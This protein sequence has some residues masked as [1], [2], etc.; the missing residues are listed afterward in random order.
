MANFFERLFRRNRGKHSVVERLALINSQANGFFSF[1]S[2]VYQSDLVRSATRP[3]VKACGKLSVRHV[4]ETEEDFRASPTPAIRI[5]LEDP[6]AFMGMQ[7]MVEKVAW[8]VKLNGNAFIYIKRNKESD[9]A[10]L[11]VLEA[12]HVELLEATGD[13]ETFLRFRFGNGK[14]QVVPYSDIIHLRGEFNDNDFFGDSPSRVLIPLMECVNAQDQGIINAIK[15]SSVIKWLLRFTSSLRPEDIEKQT[16]R[17]A[18]QYLSLDSESGGV[19]GVDSK[20]E[21]TPIKQDGQF[22]PDSKQNNSF[23]QRIFW[24]LGT[25]E[26]I[27]N[28][29]YS[30]DE[31]IAWFESEV[32]PFAMQISGEFT[33]K[34]FSIRE[35]AHGNKI[36]FENNSL[37]FASLKSKLE[38]VQLFDRSILSGNEIRKVLGHEPTEYGN[39]YFIRREYGA[40]DEEG[41]IRPTEVLEVRDAKGGDE[42]EEES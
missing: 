14:E 25:N 26:K 15:N 21:A 39:T 16:K 24:T 11:Q 38:L 32:S 19:A 30:E 28:G 40:I 7:K 1:G 4:L 5:L 42:G 33:R 2:N 41:N 18:K 27:V 10:E 13:G 36:R 29:T 37:A 34:F 17:F 31:W 9:P 3:F 8:H 22:V 6:N 20:A 12:G 35:R 23:I